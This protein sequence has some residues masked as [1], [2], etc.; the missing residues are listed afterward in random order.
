[1]VSTSK[2][3]DNFLPDL[4]ENDFLPPLSRWTTLGSLFLVSAVAITVA[5]AAI[6]K[7]RVT[8][9]A[10]ATLRPAGELRL[11]QAATEGS[12]IEISA[13]ANQS[14][15]KGDPIAL[16]DDS[17]LQTQKSQLESKIQQAQ[18]Q[19]S[20][21]MAQ[22]RSL[23]TQIV[24]E[25]DRL[26]RRVDS[27]VAQLNQRQRDYR[28]RQITSQA[29]V[30][31]AQA[32]LM[33]AQDELDAAFAELKSIIANLQSAQVSLQASIAK[34]NRYENAA[35]AGALSLDQLEEIQLVVKQQEKNVESQI[36]NVERQKQEIE[37]GEKA[38]QVAQARLQRSET[39]LNPSSA[40]VTVARQR[41]GQEQ[42]T[43]KATLA[44][45]NKE[46][47]ALI[48]QRIDISKQLEQHIS[49]LQQVEINL[50]KTTITATADGIIAQLNLRN[51]GQTV[52]SGEEIAK[53][54]P[55]NAPLNIKAVVSPQDIGKLGNGQKVQMR[56]SACPY[57]DY[58]TLKG[59]V[60]QISEDTI[61]PQDGSFIPSVMPKKNNN[62]EAEFSSFYEVTIEPEKLVLGK[63]ENLC[64]IELGMEGRAD[65]ITR[66][67]T[68]LKF[69][70]RKARLKTGV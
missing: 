35:E 16:L 29:E 8:I 36:A 26:S 47:E 19:L 18:L 13:Q 17:R 48:Q 12:V 52:R 21:I 56:V 7:Y 49:E 37:R 59:I 1:M 25:T 51:S 6:T 34:R 43:K 70:L 5:V 14:I 10:Q 64:Q 2:H 57:P 58:G 23:D 31:E 63:D 55:S 33:L 4:D 53:I 46:R 30:E 50:T 28:D 69:L 68:F 60:T 27:A 9:K 65:I 24:A 32:N 61:K 3:K 62:K 41:I 45:L 15:K 54:V 42:A 22:L 20:Q 67:E 38:V 40:E 44:I 11:V 66:E 39:A